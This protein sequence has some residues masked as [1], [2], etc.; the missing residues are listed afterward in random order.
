MGSFTVRLTKTSFYY[1]E[2][3]FIYLIFIEVLCHHR[4]QKFDCLAIFKEFVLQLMVGLSG[5]MK[6]GL[7]CILFTS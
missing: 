5:P 3:C 6:L 4:L 1:D 2:I 7:V